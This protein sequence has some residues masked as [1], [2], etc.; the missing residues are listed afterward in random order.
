MRRDFLT[1]KIIANKMSNLKHYIN[2][3]TNHRKSAQ[4]LIEDTN[5]VINNPYKPI[6]NAKISQ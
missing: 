5:P 6:K 4:Y 3:L 1:L 2:V